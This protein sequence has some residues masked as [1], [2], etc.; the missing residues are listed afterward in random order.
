VS[1]QYLWIG[2]VRHVDQCIGRILQRLLNFVVDAREA[3]AAS[4]R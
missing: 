2:G 3:E 4:P 1:K